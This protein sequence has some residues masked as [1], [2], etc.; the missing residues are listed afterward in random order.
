M[1][2]ENRTASRRPSAA[3]QATKKVPSQPDQTSARKPDEIDKRVGARLMRLRKAR[4][5]SQV[6]LGEA[7]GVR[8]Q[9]VQR[10]ES[11]KNRLGPSR[12]SKASELFGV[13]IEYFFADESV[14]ESFD[15]VESEAPER[16]LNRAIELFSMIKDP[17][18]RKSIIHILEGIVER[19]P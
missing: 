7:L 12:L 2:E 1:T 13:K 17:Q 9:Q 16:D 5:L 11:G 3:R 18:L 10:Y 19:K 15:S 6:G 8:F 14:I 4:G